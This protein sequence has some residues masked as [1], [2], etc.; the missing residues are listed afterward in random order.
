MAKVKSSRPT[1]RERILAATGDL[2]RRKGFSGTGLKEIVKAAKAP[3]GSVY[4]FFPEGKEQLG[5][6]A[7]RVSGQA[8]NALVAT[9]FEGTTDVVAATRA[10][11]DAAA[12]MLAATD[13]QDACPIATVALEVASES[14]PMRHATA[15]V[16]ESWM[17]DAEGYLEAA[18]VARARP[19]AIR[20]FMLL[21]GAFLL[22]RSWKSTEPMRLAR[23]SAVREAL[24]AVGR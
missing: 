23:E 17:A 7:I 16:F 9:F 4:H 3:F 24:A 11:F 19:F 13:Y 2:L 12:E 15:Q 5:A 1:T 14:E 20:L 10:F 18:G 6:E 21:E 8:Y 22:C